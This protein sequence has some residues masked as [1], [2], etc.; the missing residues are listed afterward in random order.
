MP[1]NLMLEK[2]I[3]YLDIFNKKLD[4]YFQDQKE[5]IKC[6]TGCSFCCKYSYYPY[7]QLEYDYFR[8]GLQKKFTAGEREGFYQKTLQIFRDRRNFLKTNSNVF[9]FQYE[10]PF[11]VDDVCKNYEHRGVI[12]RSH[13]LIYKDIDKPKHNAP[14]CMT[15]GLNYSNIYDPET[16]Q[17]SEEKAAQL[18]FKSRPKV[19]ELSYS[20][21]MKDAGEDIDFGDVRMLF[22]WV[23][24]DIPNYEELIREN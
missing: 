14:H 24:M 11:L 5:F 15:H 7:S 23:I 20:S 8:I 6:K 16:K 13:G 4:S 10:C 3:S 21:I 19:Y 18:G 2:Y 1:E 9:D 17:F 12:C 22:E